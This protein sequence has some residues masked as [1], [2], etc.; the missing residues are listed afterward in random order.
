MSKIKRKVRPS[1]EELRLLLWSSLAIAQ[2]CLD[3]SK[4]CVEQLTEKAIADSAKLKTLDDRIALID[5][6]LGVL[7]DY[8]ILTLFEGG[9]G[10]LL[11]LPLNGKRLW[12]FA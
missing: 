2:D 8:L 5:K 9:S 3:S 1:D 4:D 11:L 7:T 12:I 6:R 10:K